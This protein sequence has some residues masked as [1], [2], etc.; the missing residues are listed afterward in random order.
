M[1]LTQRVIT[2]VLLIIAAIVAKDDAEVREDI[3]KVIDK[4]KVKAAELKKKQ[5]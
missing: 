5:A 1:N 3:L 4:I 2:E